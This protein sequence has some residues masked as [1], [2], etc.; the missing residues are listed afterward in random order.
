MC[1]C[2]RPGK[3]HLLFHISHLLD[4]CVGRGAITHYSLLANA[5]YIQQIYGALAITNKSGCIIAWKEIMTA[6]EVAGLRGS[7]R[8]CEYINLVCPALCCTTVM[9]TIACLFILQENNMKP[10]VFCTQFP[11]CIFH[12]QLYPCRICE[13]FRD[14]EGTREFLFALPRFARD[15][16]ENITIECLASC[17]C[18]EANLATVYNF[19]HL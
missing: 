9:F 12:I 3:L 16:V 11:N 7:G 4:L 5:K 13:G 1:T 19:C 6:E 18:T 8:W 17:S 10:Y 2:L 14:A 15:E